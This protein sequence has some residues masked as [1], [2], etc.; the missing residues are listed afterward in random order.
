[1]GTILPESGRNISNTIQG[2][3]KGRHV[4]TSSSLR[5]ET[6]WDYNTRDGRHMGTIVPDS[7]RQ[8]GDYLTR[9]E[10]YT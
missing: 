5:G 6:D 2:S 1:M 8:F 4:C 9:E 3:R 7:G 10:G